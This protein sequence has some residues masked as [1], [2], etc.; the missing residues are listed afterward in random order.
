MIKK[1]KDLVLSILFGALGAIY[2][3]IL[4]YLS[5]LFFIASL[6]ISIQKRGIIWGIITIANLVGIVCAILLI[7]IV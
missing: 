5:I 1:N 6:I 3:M 4:R 7:F 2:I